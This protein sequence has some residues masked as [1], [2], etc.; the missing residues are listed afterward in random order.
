MARN[1]YPYIRFEPSSAEATGGA[2]KVSTDG[3]LEQ[4]I[5]G[6]TSDL[7]GNPSYEITHPLQMLGK[8]TA[9]V[10]L[11]EGAYRSDISPPGADWAA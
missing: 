9:C 7:S 11:N 2:V 1:L 5:S 3:L 10:V 6:H 8:V 4:P